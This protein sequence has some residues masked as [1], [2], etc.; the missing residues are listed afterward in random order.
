MNV[1][2]N[3]QYSEEKIVLSRSK[4]QSL[5]SSA[6][7]NKVQVTLQST[8]EYV[9]PILDLNRFHSIYVHNIVNANTGGIDGAFSDEENVAFGGSAIN[10]YI[11][12]IITLAE[13]Q[14]AEDLIV[15]LT[16][17][18]PQGT[19][20]HVYAK[21][22]N[23]EDS[24]TF[25][26]KNWIQL[27]TLDTDTFSSIADETDFIEFDFK[28]PATY[29]TGPNDEFQYTNSASIEFSGFKQY[30]IKIVLLA[31]NSALVPKVGDLRTIALQL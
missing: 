7:S 3:T 14:D 18:R 28:I 2:N 25:D 10:K 24:D 21:F 4:E 1:E 30:Q 11:S 20:V 26:S 16:A 6:N 22:L 8:S 19:K 31:E 17:Y 13:G 27:E 5:L 12:R 29:M 15:R 23:V 9:S